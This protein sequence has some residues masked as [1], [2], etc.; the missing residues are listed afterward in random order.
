MGLMRNVFLICS[1]SVWMRERATRYGFVR[2]AVSRFMPGET[3][4]EA[5]TAARQLQAQSIG[6][7][8]TL[9][10][11][12]VKEPAEAERVTDHYLHLL[13]R[14]RA[15]QL[16]G[17][18][19]VKLTQLGLDLSAERCHASLL[20]IIETAQGSTVWIDMESS[21]Y[22]DVTLDMYRRVRKVHRNVGVCLQA[23]LYRT[24]SDLANLI[25]LGSAIRLVKGAYKES[26]AVA[27]AEKAKVD[28]NF[29]ELGREL[30]SATARNAGVRAAI[31]THDVN[32]IRRITDYVDSHKLGRT[33][34]EFQMLY[35]IQ[36]QE[37]LRLAREGW[38]SIV[39]V[40]YGSYW[41]P[42]Y[43]RRLAERPANVLFVLRN[44]LAA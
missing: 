32:L 28:E 16:H 1:E 43:M 40:A 42:W 5:L 15:L 37:Q 19:S 10:G 30:L 38:K 11:E 25:P 41:F 17:E 44:L 21:P 7:V 20:R 2:R 6:S 24:A 22:V 9:L 29:F 35:G 26:S 23:Y 31:A 34:L 12:N 33:S 14:I 13:D 36:Q 4:E 27:F 3:A 39:L 8:F 18:V